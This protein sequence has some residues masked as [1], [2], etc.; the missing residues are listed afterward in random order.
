MIYLVISA[1]FC[2][3]VT[4]IY[5]VYKC[6]KPKKYKKNK[7]NLQNLQN[8]KNDIVYVKYNDSYDLPV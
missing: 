1:F 6:I 4:I 3:N 5:M 7:K 2:F 8:I